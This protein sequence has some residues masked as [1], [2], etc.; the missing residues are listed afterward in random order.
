MLINRV[1]IVSGYDGSGCGECY[2]RHKFTYVLL[3]LLE[4]TFHHFFARRGSKIQLMLW[5]ANI[6]PKQFYLCTV[7]QN[8]MD[9]LA[10]NL[11]CKNLYIQMMTER[12]ILNHA[13]SENCFVLIFRP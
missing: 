6:I 3:P 10:T 5:Y 11:L 7:N 4:R 13:G 2:W 8:I 9:V 1:S 12:F